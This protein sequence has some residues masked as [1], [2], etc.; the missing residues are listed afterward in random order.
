MAKTAAASSSTARA[1]AKQKPTVKK[2]PAA[3]GKLCKPREAKA[4]QR[5]SADAVEKQSAEATLARF[6]WQGSSD[7]TTEI[8]WD[9]YQ[10]CPACMELVESS[11]DPTCPLCGSNMA[12]DE[13]LDSSSTE[14]DASLDSECYD[15]IE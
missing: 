1:C 5:P 4:L 14:D 8:D 3:A 12:D 7:R 2:K 9:K 10:Q 11:A 15:D 6:A 13:S